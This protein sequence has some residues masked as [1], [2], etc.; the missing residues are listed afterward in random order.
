MQ[1]MRL[2]FIPFQLFHLWNSEF[3]TLLTAK[4]AI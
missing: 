2:T 3:A 4:H 1:L